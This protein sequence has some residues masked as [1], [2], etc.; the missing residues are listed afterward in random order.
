MV[1]NT[2]EQYTLRDYQRDATQ[3]CVDL[4]SRGQNKLMNVLAPGLG[5]TVIFSNIAKSFPDHAKYG[6][7]ILV[8]RDELVFQAAEKIEKCNP[9]STVGIEKA[10]YRADWDCD[11]IIASVA[12]LGRKGNSRINKFIKRCGIITTDECHHVKRGGM[13]DYILSRFGVGYKTHDDFSPLPNGL[14]RISLGFTATPNRNDRKG[15]DKFYDKVACNYTIPWGRENGWLV[16]VETY[17]EP[18]A[19][20]IT[21][22]KTRGSDFVDSDLEKAINVNERNAIIV[23]AYKKYSNGQAIAYCSGR[24]HSHE[25][26]H[27]FILS[28]IPAAAV[29]YTTDKDLRFVISK[30]FREGKIKVICNCNIYTEG[31]DFPFADTIIMAKPTKSQGAYIQM[32][33]RG[34]RP[35]GC[36]LEDINSS[37]RIKAIKKSSKPHCKLLDFVD[38]YNSHSLVMNP[39]LAGIDVPPDPRKNTNSNGRILSIGGDTYGYFKKGDELTENTMTRMSEAN[40][41]PEIDVDMILADGKIEYE[42]PDH[43]SSVSSFKWKRTESSTY[44]IRANISKRD[45]TVRLTGDEFN[46]WKLTILKHAKISD[47]KTNGKKDWTPQE[48]IEVNKPVKGLEKAIQKVDKWIKKRESQIKNYDSL[49]IEREREKY[50]RKKRNSKR[51]ATPAMIY[52]IRNNIGIQVPDNLSY[53][54]ALHIIIAHKKSNGT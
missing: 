33:G 24:V 52:S 45:I 1:E 15:L 16:P 21:G 54:N 48:I 26:A 6:K 49:L 11:F 47:R 5:K 8:H 44:E 53:N 38:V 19:V 35:F 4:V 2:P 39:V 40:V 18:T 46:E 27:A 25:L 14:E 50:R 23:G 31:T 28:G 42:I 13:Y 43:I 36:D 34:F 7:L 17:I 29:D 32:A 41:L 10:E 30:S 3:I 12:T 51:K 22:V 9:R 37:E 20:D